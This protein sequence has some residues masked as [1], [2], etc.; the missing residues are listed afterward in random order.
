MST[1]WKS[2]ARSSLSRAVSSISSSSI[3]RVA[4]ALEARGPYLPSLSRV[5]ATHEL[6]AVI[7]FSS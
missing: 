1:S 7:S 3:C 6:I 5:L 4:I 2:I